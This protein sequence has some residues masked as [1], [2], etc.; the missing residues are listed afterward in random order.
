MHN[1]NVEILNRRVLETAAM[2]NPGLR[3]PIRRWV[4]IVAGA[5]WSSL[6]DVRKTFPSADGVPVGGGMVA[7]VFNVG[8][9]RYRIITAVFYEQQRVYISEVL[10]HAEYD[11]DQWK[12]RL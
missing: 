12:R 7:T 8:G 11:K 4:E 2:K 9:N 3:I 10:T 6:D 1:A 5:E